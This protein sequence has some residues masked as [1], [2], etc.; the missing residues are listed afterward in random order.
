MIDLDDIPPALSDKIRDL[1][2]DPRLISDCDADPREATAADKSVKDHGREQSHVDVSARDDQSDTSSGV[3]RL[4][5]QNRRE[6]GGPS[7]LR[8]DLSGFEK[9]HHG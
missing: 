9:P 7:T 5:A 2:Q 3:A 6:R 1:R 4:L 8:Y